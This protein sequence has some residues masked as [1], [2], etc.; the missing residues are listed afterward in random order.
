M[1]T[2][3]FFEKTIVD[4]IDLEPY[5]LDNDAYLYDKIKTTYNIFKREYGY[6]IERIGER[7]AFAEWLQGLPSALSVPFYYYEILE[8]AKASG[9][10]VKDEDKLFE[11][12]FTDLSDAF[13]TIKE[14]L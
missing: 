7:K 9:I 1:K 8:N 13:F 6:M 10:E 14:N 12:Y 2:L 3:T 5:G 4:N 11:S